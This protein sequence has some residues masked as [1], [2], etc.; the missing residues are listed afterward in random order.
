M[1]AL[2]PR[3]RTVLLLIDVDQLT[4]AE[5]AEVLDVPVGTVMSRLSR[6]RGKVR[7]ELRPIPSREGTTP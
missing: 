4:Y 7:R 6:T 1:A 5:T 3:Y 2:D